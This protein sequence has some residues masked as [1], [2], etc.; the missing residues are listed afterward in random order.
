MIPRNSST[1]ESTGCG[2]GFTLWFRGVCGLAAF[3]LVGCGDP[4]PAPGPLSTSES[5]GGNSRIER[6]DYLG[7]AMDVTANLDKYQLQEAQNM[8]LQYLYEWRRGRPETSVDWRRDPLL[9]RLPDRLKDWRSPA[10]R[11]GADGDLFSM[12][13]FN[14]YDLFHLRESQWMRDVARRAKSLE[15]CPGLV[16]AW[17]SQMPDQSGFGAEERDD[18]RTTARLFDWV[19]RNIQLDAPLTSDANSAG[20]GGTEAARWGALPGTRYYPWESLAL[21]HGDAVMRARVFILMARQVGVT[22]VMLA[23]QDDVKNDPR[24]WLPAALIGQQLYLFDTRL[25]LPIPA[26][27]GLGIATLEQL[28]AEPSRLESLDIDAQRP[29]P[30]RAHQLEKLVVLLDADPLSLSQRMK[31]VELA[32]SGDRKVILTCEPLAM[33]NRLA[34]LAGVR[35]VQ[36]W[37]APYDAFEFRRALSTDETLS[38]AT[39]RE[40]RWL[41]ITSPLLLGRYRQ[42]RGQIENVA[43]QPGAVG[44]YLQARVPEEQLRQLQGGDALKQLKN[45]NYPLPE[46][47]AA[48]Q[49][50]VQD[51]ANM[52]REMKQAASY[53]LGILAM[54]SGNY[55]VAVDH[56]Q[57]RTLTASPDS[58]WTHGARYNLARCYEALAWP[59]HS[60][61]RRDEAIRA[62]RQDE[63][64]PQA[65]GNCWRARWLEAVTP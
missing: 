20:E 64:S 4:L 62:Y 58:P 22:A 44:L 63:S 31:Q 32:L 23:I 41:Y 25:G 6:V 37:A 47:P 8:V 10:A 46:D 3:V 65:D 5:P 7:A 39:E 28:V 57:K 26:P 42:F 49:Q 51:S 11:G 48:Q 9:G 19:I 56:F 55:S 33:R 40:R 50:M 29:Y 16:D 34:G 15:T 35:D 54:E 1:R 30:V 59:E 18:L 13:D 61:P 60:V 27:E 21:G 52:L 45:L 43:Q 53:W 24:P 36:L 17:I 38:R 12:T 2:G 14:A